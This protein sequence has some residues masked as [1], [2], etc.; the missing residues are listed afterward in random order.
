MS[1]KRYQRILVCIDQPA[2]DAQMLAYVGYLSRL[3]E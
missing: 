1:I 3:A 2:T